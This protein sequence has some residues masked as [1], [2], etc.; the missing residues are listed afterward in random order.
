MTTVLSLGV[1]VSALF[2]MLYVTSPV[3]ETLTVIG[4]ANLYPSGALNSVKRYSPAGSL[5]VVGFNPPSSL[6]VHIKSL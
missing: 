6:V 3:A 2:L 5:N 1:V 4:S